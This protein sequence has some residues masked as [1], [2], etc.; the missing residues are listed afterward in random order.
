MM[1]EVLFLAAVVLAVAAG[2][3]KWGAR[4]RSVSFLGFSA[5]ALL[6][7]LMIVALAAAKMPALVVHTVAGPLTYAPTPWSGFWGTVGEAL[8]LVVGLVFWNR[9]FGKGQWVAL[10]WLAVAV[11]AFLEAASPLAM[12]VAWGVLAI[13]VYGMVV[14]QGSSRRAAAAGWAMLVM[15]EAGAAALL[16][17]ALLLSPSVG[18]AA[19]GL[20]GLIAVLGI[21]GLGSKAGLF[22]F[23]IWLPLAEPE[24]PGAA[25]AALSGVT[26]T[27]AMVGLMRWLSWAPP[28]APIAWGMVAVGLIGALLGVIH[29]IVDGDHKRVLA[30]STVE[31]V[32][33]AFASLGLSY[34]L[35]DAGQVAAAAL[36]LSGAY[37]LLVMH[38]GAKFAAFFA[39]GW[40]E[41][42]T[43]TRELN[44]LG[45]LFRSAP[46]AAGL[47]LLAAAG[48]MAMPPTGGYVAEWMALESIFMGASSSLRPALLVVVLA[49]ALVTAGGAT[50]ILRW[51]AAI[52]LGPRRAVAESRPRP[53]EIVG[54]AFG[55]L[56]AWGAGVGT[57][58]LVPW[59]A[60][61][62]PRALGANGIV[63][64]TF[65]HPGQTALLDSLGGRLFNGLP[66]TQ[67]VIL[68]PGGGFTATSPWDL[69][70][71]GGAIVGAVALLRWLWLRR[72]P[73]RAAAPSVWSGGEDYTSAYGWTAD[74]LAQPLRLAFAPV[75]RLRRGRTVGIDSIEV[76]TD[77]VDRLLTNLFEPLLYA[78]RWLTQAVRR[79]QSGHLSHYLGYIMVVLMGGI[80]WLKLSGLL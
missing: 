38:M 6:L 2:F 79:L 46:V 56:L 71:F 57:T 8:L 54:I 35:R 59:L 3:A 26:T 32:G 67:G 36:A 60:A 47:T 20:T 27:V 13:A 30:Y 9:E 58:W 37:T 14:A 23:Q 15:S 51:Y 33:L 19:H 48:L 68:F 10:A 40:I 61:E 74:G 77:A 65:T 75:I 76:Q 24:S 28:S 11:A 42:A 80:V 16:L 72:F 49:V 4:H 50:A 78:A 22:P 17:G 31:W 12:V 7:V 63:A 62:S 53:G 73:R 29:A 1:A 39:S 69:L 21:L 18:S 41:R 64:P 70:W 52:F 45:G 5:I 55:A 34:V 25:A 66:G 43:G 44:R